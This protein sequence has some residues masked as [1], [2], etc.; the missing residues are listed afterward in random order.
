MKLMLSQQTSFRG[1]V[2]FFF[3]NVDAIVLNKATSTLNRHEN[4]PFRK[5]SSNRRYENEGLSLFMWTENILK[6]DF[7]KTMTSR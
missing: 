4:G 2:R 6:K 5:R 1:Y 3:Q 7:L